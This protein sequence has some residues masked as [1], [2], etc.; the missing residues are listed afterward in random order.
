MSEA[1]PCGSGLDYAACCRPIIQGKSKAA[2]AESLMRSRYTAYA[3]GE[4]NYIVSSCVPD[5]DI[6]PEATKNWSRKAEWLGLRIVRTEKGGASD[7][8]GVVEFVADYV[9]DGLKDEH[10]ETAYF[11]K[12]DGSWLYDKGDVKA[13]TVVRAAPKVGRNEPC[14]CGSGKKYK[15]CCG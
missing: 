11:V 9:M 12:K 10:R 4:I 7:S 1:C 15:H 6:D 5:S 13:A 3:K 2:T 14:P 8:E